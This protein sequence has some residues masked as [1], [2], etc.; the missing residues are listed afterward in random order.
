MESQALNYAIVAGFF[1]VMGIVTLV[2]RKQA[3]EF[4]YET[5]GKFPFGW[6]MWFGK[7]TLLVIHTVLAV[8]ITL[9]A[10][11]ALVVILL[12]TALGMPLN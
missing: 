10:F 6:H 3:M 12:K 4:Y 11:G 9:G 8:L 5:V 2:F 7:R 1:L